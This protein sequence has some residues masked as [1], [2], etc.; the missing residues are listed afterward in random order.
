MV[1]LVTVE[2]DLINRCEL[3]DEADLDA[4]L[5]RFDELSRPAPRLENA[6]TRVLERLEAYFAARDWDAIAEI[7]ADD[8]YAD[9]RRRV[10]N[11][12][13]RHGRDAEIASMR[14]I[15]EVGTQ[16]NQVDRDCDPRRTPCPLSYPLVRAQPGTRSVPYR[17]T[18]HPRDRRGRPDRGA[19]RVRPRRHRRRL[20]GAR[21][22]IPRRR[23][24]RALAHVVSHHA[25]LR[26]AQPA[27]TSRDDAG[28]G[29]HRPPA[30][31]SGRA[32]RS[33]PVHPCRVGRHAA[34][35][36]THRGCAS[37]ERTSERS[38]PTCRKGPQKRAS[39][40]N[41]GRSTL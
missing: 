40:P 41:G 38:S 3:F 30:R 4:A 37:A 16:K 26:R 35:Q 29:E 19:H 31:D 36:G 24:R 11:S 14:A 22:P 10:V 9:D 25:G 28:L 39:T 5:A 1:E 27:R 32:R 21:R 15:A 12:G 20:R 23:S 8:T 34:H 7:L 17:R 33:D 2:G 6:A 13:T 18:H